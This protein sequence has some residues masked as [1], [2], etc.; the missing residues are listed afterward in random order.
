[1]GGANGFLNPI[2][3]AASCPTGF[4]AQ[5][6]YGNASSSAFPTFTDQNVFICTS[7]N[8]SVTQVAAFGGIYSTFAGGATYKNPITS[9]QTCPQGFNS[10]QFMGG[11]GTRDA[12][13]YFCYAAASGLSA[14]LTWAFGGAYGAHQNSTNMLQFDDY[15]NPASNA[16]NCPTNFINFPVVGELLQD[17]A[18]RIC[19]MPQNSGTLGSPATLPSMPPAGLKGTYYSGIGSGGAGGTIVGLRVDSMINYAV[20]SG[21]QSG[22]SPIAALNGHPF[23]ENFSVQYSGFIML[24]YSAT[25]NFYTYV[26]DGVMLRINDQVVISAWGDHDHASFTSAGIALEGGRLYPFQLDFYN[27]SQEYA[28]ALSYSSVAPA[29]VQQYVPATRFFHTAF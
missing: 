28:I 3:N 27:R 8:A 9:A 5:Q 4:T 6:I 18:F 1:V 15:P 13:A 26:D 25:Y 29:M 10:A 22:S 21:S 19:L 24:P 2:T 11:A 23:S 14:D 12:T 20:G 16:G 17:N 7:N